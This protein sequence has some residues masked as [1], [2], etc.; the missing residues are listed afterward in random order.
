[1]GLLYDGGGALTDPGIVIQSLTDAGGFAGN[2]GAIWRD[3]ALSLGGIGRPNGGAGGLVVGS[4]AAATSPTTGA[5]TV[6]GGVGVAGNMKIAGGLNAGNVPAALAYAHVLRL[7]TDLNL[8]LTG[9]AGAIG[10]VGLNDAN[11]AYVPIKISA[12]TA[13]TSPTTGALTVAGGVGIGGSIQSGGSIRNTGNIGADGIITAGNTSASGYYYFGNTGTK[14][15]SYDGT[16]F[17]LAGGNLTVLGV[18]VGVNGMASTGPVSVANLTSNGDI[19]ALHGNVYLQSSAAGANLPPGG[20]AMSMVYGGAT[21]FGTLMRC[22]NDSA[23]YLAIAFQNSGAAAIGSISC[24]VGATAFNTSSS[25]ELKED[26]KTFDAGNIIDNTN[27]YDFKWKSH[28]ERGYGVLA[29]QAVEVYPTAVTHTINPET[30]D[31]FWGVDYSKY[32]P[33]LLQELK[34]LRARVFELESRVGVGIT[35][36]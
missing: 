10:L 15:L 17:S 11:N 23:G 19:T 35:P 9:D 1:M 32:V 12:N 24:T 7:S 18:N 13:S 26:L 5:L 27:V 6:A 34:A 16:N 8:C 21:Q 3:G 36:A 14:Y 31:E 30:K 2:S 29:Q 4:S 20:Y 25:A 33:V 28:D 22:V